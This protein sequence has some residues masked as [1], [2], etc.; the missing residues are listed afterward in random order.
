MQHSLS[1]WLFD[2]FRFGRQ[3]SPEGTTTALHGNTIGDEG[4]KMIADGLGKN[5]HLEEL[6]IGDN[7]I[8]N[9]GCL[10]LANATKQNC[11]VWQL[12]LR[13]DAISAVGASKMEASLMHAN[14]M[15]VN[16]NFRYNNGVTAEQQDRFHHRNFL[17]RGLCA[18]FVGQIY[19][20]F[21]RP[22]RV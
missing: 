15:L 2:F 11:S 6:Y 21:L 7:N 12:C 10:A 4:A 19:G 20:Q 3:D 22:R 13:N 1:K 8:G 9:E 16:V 18:F 14:F 5:K 17:S